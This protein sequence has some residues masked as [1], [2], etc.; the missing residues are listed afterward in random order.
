MGKKN[1]EGLVPAT[2]NL[3]LIL[4]CKTISYRRLQQYNPRTTACGIPRLVL[5]RSCLTYLVPH[6]SLVSHHRITLSS[7]S[8]YVLFSFAIFPC[9]L[10]WLPTLRMCVD[11]GQDICK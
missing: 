8:A 7:F 4:S 11:N 10:R 6:S 9:Y 2:P 5:S 1:L 3:L